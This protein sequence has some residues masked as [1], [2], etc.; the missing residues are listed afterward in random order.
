MAVMTYAEAARLAVA[1]ALRADD[2]CQRPTHRKIKPRLP[3]RSPYL[4]AVFFAP[5]QFN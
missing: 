2:R 5:L 1:D 4:V 3:T